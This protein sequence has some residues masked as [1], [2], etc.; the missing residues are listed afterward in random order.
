M[1][2]KN[3]DSEIALRH[4]FAIR[5]PERANDPAYNRELAARVNALVRRNLS[6]HM[7]VKMLLKP[8]DLPA[9]IQPACTIRSR[10]SRSTFSFARKKAGNEAEARWPAESGPSFFKAFILNP[11]GSV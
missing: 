3:E 5:Y 10:R 8:L 2:I 1:E 7:C 9:R 11:E 6:A 4:V